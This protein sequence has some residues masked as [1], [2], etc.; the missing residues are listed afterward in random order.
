[1]LT[2][3]LKQEWQTWKVWKKQESWPKFV[4]YG[5]TRSLL[6]LMRKRS[7]PEFLLRVNWC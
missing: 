4:V 3:V 2:F 7:R 1:M 6:M 5:N